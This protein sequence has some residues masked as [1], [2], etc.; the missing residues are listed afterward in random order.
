MAFEVDGETHM[1]HAEPIEESFWLGY[2]R[3]LRRAN[4]GN[5]FGTNADHEKWLALDDANES[6]LSL[7]GC[8]AL[9]VPTF[10]RFLSA[11]ATADVNPIP[12]K[13]ERNPL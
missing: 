13:V 5:I 9:S 7:R 12:Q 4:S 3:G 2:I 6:D 8:R 11:L 10:R 1:P